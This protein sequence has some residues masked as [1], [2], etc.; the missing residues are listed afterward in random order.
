MVE[1]AS[2]TTPNSDSDIVLTP[3]R[4]ETQLPGIMAMMD[5]ELSEPYSIFT[6]RYFIHGW[7]QLC[8]LAHHGEDMVGVVVCKAD[9]KNKCQRYRGYIAM[10]A[11]DTRFRR[12][13][14]GS[15]LVCSAIAKMREMGCDEAVLETEITNTAAL[16]LYAKLGFLRDK[17]LARYYLNGVDAFRLKLWFTPPRTGARGGSARASDAV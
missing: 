11:V 17:R 2:A 12:R 14:L 4:D 8:I 6:Y 7:P 1:L 10:L 13:H 3:Y 16:R 9:R 5:E 15:K